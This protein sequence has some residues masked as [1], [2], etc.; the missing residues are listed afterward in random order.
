MKRESKTPVLER[1][2]PVLVT[3]QA[4]ELLEGFNILASAS[5]LDAQSRRMQPLT[6]DNTA[7]LFAGLAD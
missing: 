1:K 6:Y 2:T 7:G 5:P 4:L 3:Y